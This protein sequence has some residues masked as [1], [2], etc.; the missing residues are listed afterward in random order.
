MSVDVI[1]AVWRSGV[2]DGSNLIVLLAL[3]DWAAPDGT[4]VYPTI[5]QI[6]EKARL[7]ERGARDC[8]RKLK[9]DGFLILVK[10][11]DGTRGMA[12]EWRLD[13]AKLWACAGETEKKSRGQ[14][15]GDN[16]ATGANG[17]SH[18]G[19][20]QL[21]GGKLQQIPHT[22]YIDST[23]INNRHIQP[24]S[25]PG[26]ASRAKAS[27]QG[28]EPEGF[29]EFYQAYPRHEGRGQAERAYRAARKIVSAEILLEG[30]ERYAALR[31]GE[32]AQYTKH[33]A[34]W[35]N[36]KGWL[37]EAL[38]VQSATVIPI[39]RASLFDW[40][41]RLRIY[42]GY[43]SEDKEYPLPKGTWNKSWGPAPHEQGHKVPLE[44]FAKIK[45]KV[46]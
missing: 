1:T 45:P 28:E 9:G 8:L 34:T 32:P 6:M 24:S 14:I 19:K 44:A 41:E 46:A 13:V 35:L 22:P 30:A 43:V 21:H 29:A 40:E 12:N 37:D 23:V 7:S 36:G 27:K 17:D 4:R 15:E 33:P 26:G 10:G 3:A 42:Y 2:Y 39:A 31:K 11:S 38:P 18:G 5:R 25:A 20:L 16:Y